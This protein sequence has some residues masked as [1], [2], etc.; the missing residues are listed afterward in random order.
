MITLITGGVRSGKSRYAVELAMRRAEKRV[1][2]A[3]AEA[4]DDEMKLRIAN[5]Q[6]ERGNAFQT[7]EAP[8][9]LADAVMKAAG[10]APLTVID[11]LT[12]WVGNLLHHFQGKDEAMAAELQSFI[13]TAASRPADIILVTNEVGFGIMPENPLARRFSDLLGQL[14]QEMARHSDEVILMVSGI[15]QVIKGQIYHA[16]LD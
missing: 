9:F 16:G 13:Q 12:V 4:L 7:V 2:I 8:V 1:F 6:R 11:C 5:H 15:P 14:N 10:R 3:T